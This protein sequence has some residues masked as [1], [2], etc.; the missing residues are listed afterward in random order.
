MIQTW[1]T[2]NFPAGEAIAFKVEGP[3]G[4]VSESMPYILQ[5]EIAEEVWKRMGKIMERRSR[6]EDSGLRCACRRGIFRSGL[7]RLVSGGS[8]SGGDRFAR[9]RFEQTYGQL[10][11]H[12]Y[13]PDAGVLAAVGELA[14]WNGAG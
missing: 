12:L 3:D 11:L 5:L 7:C 1:S 9:S 4:G 8:C 6:E 13:A 14:S 2:P 10:L